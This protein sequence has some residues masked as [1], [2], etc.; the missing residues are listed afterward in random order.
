MCGSHFDGYASNA[1]TTIVVG[2]G[3]VSGP[4]A[5]CILAAWNAYQAALR[6]IGEATTNTGVTEVIQQVAE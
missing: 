5:D 6:K 3:P 4:K 2:A 1:A